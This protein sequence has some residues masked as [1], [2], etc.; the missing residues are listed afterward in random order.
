MRAAWDAGGAVWGEAWGAARGAAREAA[1]G[2]WDTSGGGAR[3]PCMASEDQDG[4]GSAWWRRPHAAG[5]DCS[6]SDPVNAV[7]PVTEGMLPG[8][9]ERDNVVLDLVRIRI[10]LALEA[11]IFKTALG[12]ARDILALLPRELEQLLILF[13]VGLVHPHVVLIH[14]LALLLPRIA[15]C[16]P[17]EAGR[18][19]EP[20]HIDERRRC[21]E[22]PGIE[23]GGISTRCGWLSS[24]GRRNSRQRGGPPRQQVMLLRKSATT[25]GR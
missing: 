3:C 14:R 1:G 23:P 13:V 8:L 2:N 18:L 5:L 15:R 20:V 10:A 16:A 25:T 7:P 21:G 22:P 19:P 12:S 11:Q 6:P 4:R 17:G 24:H 9:K